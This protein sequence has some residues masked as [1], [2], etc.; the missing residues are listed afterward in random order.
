MSTSLWLTR[1]GAIRRLPDH[2]PSPSRAP[3]SCLR[4][5]CASRRACARALKLLPNLTP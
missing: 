1:S 2:R 5:R 4:P 3:G